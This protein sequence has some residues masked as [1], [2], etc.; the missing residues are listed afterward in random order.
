MERVHIIGIV[1]AKGNLFVCTVCCVEEDSSTLPPD[2]FRIIQ[3]PSSGG[4]LHILTKV[5]QIHVAS[6]Y[7][8][9]YGCIGEPIVCTVCCVEED[10][11]T[12]H[13][14]MFRII[15]DPS[16]GGH[17]HILTKKYLQVHGVRP[18]SRH[19]GCKGEPI[20]VHCL[21]CRR[22]L[23]YTS[24]RHVSVHTRSIFRGPSSYPD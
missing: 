23:F 18:Y 7:S 3:D 1:A 20:C 5:L 22:G 9:H 15:Q 4:H 11:S 12:L 14:D 6:L 17:H 21:L 16:S 24:P 8:R 10:S 13:P 19:C 2:V